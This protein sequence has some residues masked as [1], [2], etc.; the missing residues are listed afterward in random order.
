MKDRCF[1]IMIYPRLI[2]Y[3]DPNNLTYEKEFVRF[4][5]LGLATEVGV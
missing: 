2:V 5:K 4:K 1:C 3:K